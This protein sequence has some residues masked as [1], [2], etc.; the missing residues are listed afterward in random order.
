MP[1]RLPSKMYINLYSAF[2]LSC[3]RASRLSQ[4]VPPDA[5]FLCINAVVVDAAI[6]ERPCL[7]FLLW[8]NRR[9]TITDIKT[10]DFPVNL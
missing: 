6:E 10:L 1:Q 8:R 7:L 4:D 5:G 9:R 2:V 3:P